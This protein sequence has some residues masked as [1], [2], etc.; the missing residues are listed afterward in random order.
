MPSTSQISAF[1]ARAVKTPVEW[2]MPR[3]TAALRR[4]SHSELPADRTSGAFSTMVM[5]FSFVG[6]LV[7]LYHFRW[8]A[9]FGCSLATDFVRRRGRLSESPQSDAAT[10]E[11]LEADRTY[12]IFERAADASPPAAAAPVANRTPMMANV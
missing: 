1:L 8:F 6:P 10:V 2:P 12:Y 3:T 4:F 5:S 7:C 9:R 11:R